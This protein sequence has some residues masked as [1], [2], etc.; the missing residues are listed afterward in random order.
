MAW[1]ISHYVNFNKPYENVSHLEDVLL[2]PGGNAGHVWDVTVEDG[3]APA[4][5]SGYTAEARFQRFPYGNQFAI[6]GS[7][8]GNAAQVIFNSLVYAVPGLL[9]GVF[10]L[11]NGAVEIP[12]IEA[13]FDVRDNFTGNVSLSEDQIVYYPDAGRIAYDGKNYY[14]VSGTTAET[15]DVRD[16]KVFRKA[17]GTLATGNADFAVTIEGL[18]V[19]AE[20]IEDEDYEIIVTSGGN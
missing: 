11:V 2:V 4:D 9:R 16:G 8:D 19:T 1:K 3:G 7:V 17:D 15:G 5:L 14:D 10:F 20:L 18:S 6:Q 13:Y 12:V